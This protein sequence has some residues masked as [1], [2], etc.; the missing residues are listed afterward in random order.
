V[1][2][3]KYLTPLFNDTLNICS[4]SKC[5]FNKKILEKVLLDFGKLKATILSLKT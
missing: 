1:G 3:V 5:H 4:R 2:F